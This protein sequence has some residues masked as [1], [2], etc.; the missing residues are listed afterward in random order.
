[1]LKSMPTR[2]IIGS[3]MEKF[4]LKK[5]RPQ[6]EVFLELGMSEANITKLVRLRREIMLHRPSTIH[7]KLDFFRKTLLLSD[8]EI[9]K[10]LLKFP[11]I[12]EYSTEATL[13]P[14]LEFL[15]SVGLKMDD[16]PKILLRAPAVVELSVEN[17]LEPRLAFLRDDLGLP[18]GSLP[19]ILVKHP[20]LMTCTQESMQERADFLRSIGMNDELL[21]KSILSHPQLLHYSVDSMSARIEY[22]RSIG[23]EN[24]NLPKMLSRMPQLLG[25]NIEV[26]VA[27][28]FD[29]LCDQLGGGHQTIEKSPVFL[30]LSLEKRI[31]PRYC[32][33][34]EM[35]PRGMKLPAPMDWFKCSDKVFAGKFAKAPLEEFI[36]FKESIVASPYTFV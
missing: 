36:A 20:Q 5:G 14:R 13:V 12:L 1:M 32:F 27:P 2:D 21:G 34:K 30:A 29:F 23:V 4:S 6:L 35:S 10:V 19:N 26:N 8:E 15:M 11:R 28:K 18:E 24:T 25:L 7:R 31:I 16:M 17:T 9:K 3:I 22:F 33:M